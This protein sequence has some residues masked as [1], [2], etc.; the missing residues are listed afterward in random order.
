MHALCVGCRFT[1]NGFYEEMHAHGNPLFGLLPARAL[2]G[3]FTPK[4][5]EN[6]IRRYISDYVTCKMC[7]K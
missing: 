4:G 7:R 5:V 6:I 1:D 3:R 2:K